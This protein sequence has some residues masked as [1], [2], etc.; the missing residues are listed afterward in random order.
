MLLNAEDACRFVRV[1]TKLPAATAVTLALGVPAEEVALI[2]TIGVSV[3]AT[4]EF[5]TVITYSPPAAVVRLAVVIVPQSAFTV[6][7]LETSVPVDPAPVAYPS[8]LVLAFKFA[9][10]VVS[11]TS[12]FSSPLCVARKLALAEVQAGLSD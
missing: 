5:V 9:I 8:P 1:I 3:A 4:K 6:T 11:T 2:A 10:P 12:T 7:A